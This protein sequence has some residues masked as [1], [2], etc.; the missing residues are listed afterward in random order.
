VSDLS[1]SDA[2][3]TALHS[4]VRSVQG[5]L[6]ATPGIL[7]P[8]AALGPGTAL[9]EAVTRA[10]TALA[11]AVEVVRHDLGS[12]ERAVTVIGETFVAA[13]ESLVCSAQALR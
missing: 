10:T 1:L 4:A 5:A 3:L 7:V 8:T 12:C 9:P 6:E 11:R 2:D 13:E